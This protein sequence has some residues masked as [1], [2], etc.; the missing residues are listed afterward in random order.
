[1][2]RHIPIQ[3]SSVIEPTLLE[4]LQTMINKGDKARSML[5]ATLA[6]AALGGLLTCAAVAPGAVH[7]YAR[8]KRASRVA[9]K[10][11]Y[12]RI[13]RN[14]YEL[15]KRGDLVFER[16]RDGIHIYQLSEKGI[17]KVRKLA[18]QCL[19]I[20][21]PKRWDKKWRLVLF[22][23]PESHKYQ[24]DLLQ[25]KLREM[26]FYPCQ[27][28]A[29]IHPFPCSELIE[30]LKNLYNIKPFVKLFLVDEM[31]DGKAIYYFRFL[32]KGSI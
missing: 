3:F 31:S 18:G 8:M 21:K 5:D 1:M 30:F 32:L 7:A 6:F 28:S 15:K 9:K 11:E 20:E 25:K 16:E 13:W 2:P 19:A 4:R 23:I 22:D 12:K 14:F 10:E 29:W 24:R 27:K 26:G 17:K